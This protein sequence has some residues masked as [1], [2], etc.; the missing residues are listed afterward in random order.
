MNR[1]SPTDRQTGTGTDTAIREALLDDALRLLTD[2]GEEIARTFYRELG[3]RHP[4]IAQRFAGTDLDAQAGRL[5]T[6][7]RSIVGHAGNTQRLGVDAM[8]LGF[9]HAERGIDWSE[10]AQFS[11]TLATILAE[12]QTSVP[13]EAAQRLWIEELMAIAEVMLLVGRP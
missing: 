6:M 9:R 2:R 11:A 3:R 8:R 5:A 7:L 10:Y 12:R 1:R 4:H 13:L